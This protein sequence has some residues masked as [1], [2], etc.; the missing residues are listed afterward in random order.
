MN[1]VMHV[2]HYEYDSYLSM[3][4]HVS[5][6]ITLN[7]NGNDEGKNGLINSKTSAHP[8]SVAIENDFL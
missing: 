1:H 4:L 5:H 8:I 7:A 6:L 2:M 3:R